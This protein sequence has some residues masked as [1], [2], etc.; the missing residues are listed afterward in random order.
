[1]HALTT[2][3]QKLLQGVVQD[4]WTP[5]GSEEKARTTKTEIASRLLKVA[6]QGERNPDRLR[7]HAMS[8]VITFPPCYW[9][10]Q[11]PLLQTV[12]LVERLLTRVLARLWCLAWLPGSTK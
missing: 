6:A 8:G 12:V 11:C 3:T 1:M 7:M 4:T 2:E 10:Q 5:L 9:R